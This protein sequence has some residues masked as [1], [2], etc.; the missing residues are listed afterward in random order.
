MVP[1]SLYLAVLGHL[2]VAMQ[3]DFSNAT[4]YTVAG[5]LERQPIRSTQPVDQEPSTQLQGS[6]EGD[7]PKYSEVPT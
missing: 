4:E 3:P 7:A 1:I 2:S 5:W 6:T